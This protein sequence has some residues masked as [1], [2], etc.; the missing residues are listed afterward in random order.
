M[1][2]RNNIEYHFI[3]IVIQQLFDRIVIK[4]GGWKGKTLVRDW[5]EAVKL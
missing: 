2:K 1:N 3:T 4:C 5:K